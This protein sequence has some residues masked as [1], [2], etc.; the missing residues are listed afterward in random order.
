[1][2][3]NAHLKA[4]LRWQR[5]MHPHTFSRRLDE[6]KGSGKDIEF[7]FIHKLHPVSHSKYIKILSRFLNLPD[8]DRRTKRESLVKL[9]G[10]GE[11]LMKACQRARCALYGGAFDSS[12][13][14]QKMIQVAFSM[15]THCV[16]YI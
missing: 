3:E 16:T 15:C 6:R 2:N 7:D 11:S 5:N 14:S 8:T 10:S 4:R 1:M 13:L 12:D 9:V